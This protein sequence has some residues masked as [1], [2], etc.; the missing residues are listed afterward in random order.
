M[1]KPLDSPVFQ[2]LF[3]KMNEYSLPI[4]MH[5]RTMRG[6]TRYLDE[7]SVPKDIIGF[8]AL[9]PYNWPFET[10]IAMGRLVFSGIYERYPS[11]K[12]LTHHMGGFVPF[13]TERTTYFMQGSEMRF[14]VDMMPK[15]SFTKN[16]AE[17]YK[18]SYSDTAW[19]G[20]TRTLM[21]GMIFS[22]RTTSSS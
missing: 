20:A 1:D 19:Y 11:L 7:A 2:P 12:A 17:Y 5:P 14:G 10:T 16:W 13:H 15:G 22:G 9:T 3:E 8:C 4:Q 18:M 6:G 21:G